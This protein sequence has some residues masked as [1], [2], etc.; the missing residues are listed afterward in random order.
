MDHVQCLFCNKCFFFSLMYINLDSVY[1]IERKIFTRF[2]GGI[3]NQD[4]RQDFISY[5]INHCNK[6]QLTG[7]FLS[8]VEDHSQL[9][10]FGRHSAESRH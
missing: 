4:S 5:F 3:N 8:N 1:T 10:I 6:A 2:F 9:C 7:V